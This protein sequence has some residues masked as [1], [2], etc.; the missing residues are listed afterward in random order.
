MNPAQFK[1]ALREERQAAAMQKVDTIPRPRTLAQARDLWSRDGLG[2]PAAPE[3]DG[4]SS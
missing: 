3:S 2:R 4:G 1:K